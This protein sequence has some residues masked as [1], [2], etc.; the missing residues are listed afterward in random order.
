MFT[1]KIYETRQ[2]KVIDFIIGFV[3][4][5][6]LN[7]LITGCFILLG[8]LAE[9]FPSE[10]YDVVTAAYSCL[11]LF[12]NLLGLIAFAFWRYWISLGALAAWATG[13]LL[14]LCAAL[15]FGAYCFYLYSGGM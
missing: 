14:S 1:R 12:I 10:V 2:E 8:T 6:I 15:A 5:I 13:L 3:G 4:I 7:L 9:D 11:P